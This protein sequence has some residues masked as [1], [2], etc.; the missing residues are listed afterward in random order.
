MRHIAKNGR[1][2]RPT[3]IDCEWDFRIKDATQFLVADG[4]WILVG[5]I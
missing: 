2:S 1:R 5:S 3:R 4:A